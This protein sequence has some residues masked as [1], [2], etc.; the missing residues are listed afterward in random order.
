MTKTINS[1]EG[2]LKTKVISITLVMIS[3][4]V[5]SACASFSSLRPSILSRLLPHT[6]TFTSSPTPT[7]TCTLTATAT[8]TPTLTAT[9]TASQTLT[10]TP[11]F[12][13]SPRATIT[14]A[15]TDVSSGIPVDWV[16]YP[17]FNFYISLP[18]S[19]ATFDLDKDSIEAI[20][21]HLE[22]EDE[23][24]AKIAVKNLSAETIDKTIKFWA[25]DTGDSGNDI[26]TVNITFQRADDFLTSQDLCVKMPL[27][28]QKIGF[29]V[30]DNKC[31]LM[32]HGLDTGRFIV[33][34]SLNSIAVR[35]YQYFY[36]QGRYIWVLTMSADETNWAS[37]KGTFEW[38]ASSFR[39]KP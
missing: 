34:V 24:W 14:F 13:A 2:N 12:T 17:T 23:D 33:R 5:V 20:I 11:S 29:E 9:V 16:E 7:P 37:K 15:N 6:A 22:G 1:Q 3:F 32:V 30:V 31:G 28:Y 38:I 35:Q 39:V 36:I 4:F 8:S 19:W 26:T 25:M 10:N 21:E 27:A 18:P